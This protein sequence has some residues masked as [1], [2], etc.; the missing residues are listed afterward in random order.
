MQHTTPET[1]EAVRLVSMYLSK[2]SRNGRVSSY[3]RVRVVTLH[4]HWL[5]S[6]GCY[7][8]IFPLRL[9]MRCARSLHRRCG[10]SEL[11]F[12]WSFPRLQSRSSWPTLPGP[13]TP[14]RTRASTEGKR[15]FA[16]ISQ[17]RRRPPLGYLGLLG[18]TYLKSV[19]N[20][21]V[22]VGAFNPCRD[23]FRDCETSQILRESL[24]EALAGTQPMDRRMH[25]LHPAMPGLPGSGSPGKNIISVWK[26]IAALR[27]GSEWPRTP[28]SYFRLS[29]QLKE[30]RHK[31]S[32]WQRGVT[33]VW[34]SGLT[35]SQRK[36]KIFFFLLE[37]VFRLHH[38]GE[39]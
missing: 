22:L 1:Q 37:K 13:A 11:I 21:K 6:L 26:N 14:A 12:N 34:A 32:H 2:I 24:F 10:E 27:G 23:L 3:P 38:F 18:Q 15:K 35:L 30:I 25:A 39:K 19:L 20:V 28:S 5:E 31:C 9:C 29:F 36:Q 17:S 8:H 33:W 16:K 4:L 7:Q